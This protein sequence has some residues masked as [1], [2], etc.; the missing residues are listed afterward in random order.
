[1]FASGSND[2]WLPAAISLIGLAFGLMASL[3]YSTE[4]VQQ[5]AMLLG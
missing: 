1:M 4:L 2:F 3:S 5:A